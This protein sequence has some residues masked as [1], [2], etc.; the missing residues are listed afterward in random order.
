MHFLLVAFKTINIK[1]EFKCNYL[2]ILKIMG[3]MSIANLS[4]KRQPSS[5]KIQ[6]IATF[7]TCMAKEHHILITRT[8]NAG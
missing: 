1:R 4:A 2:K 6:D 3:V 7:L 8:R 5:S